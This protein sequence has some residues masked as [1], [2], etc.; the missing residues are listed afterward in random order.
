MDAVTAVGI[1]AT[2]VATAN[3]VFLANSRLYRALNTSFSRSGGS[4]D[5]EDILSDLKRLQALSHA[6]FEAQ[7]AA[8]GTTDREDEA[9]RALIARL[10][11]VLILLNEVETKL[12]KPRNKLD[13][14]LSRG[15]WKYDRDLLHQKLQATIL[16]LEADITRSVQGKSGRMRC[17]HVRKEYP[18]AGSSLR[19]DLYL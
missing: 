16:R 2:L 19:T 18:M 17:S 12:Q 4:S 14:V 11:D 15:R 1:A 7:A 13:R 9:Q 5:L 3:S 6:L 8:G 10:Q